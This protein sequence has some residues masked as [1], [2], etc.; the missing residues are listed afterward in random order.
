MNSRV[1]RII[2]E[3]PTETAVLKRL[4]TNALKPH[5]IILAAPVELG[6]NVGLDRLVARVVQ[7]IKQHPRDTVST[8]IDYYGRARGWTD[9]HEAQNLPVEALAAKTEDLLY[10]KVRSQFSN[11]G[12]P[13][14]FLPHVQMHEIE[15]LL[16]ARADLLAKVFERPDL[17]TKV[18]ACLQGLHS[19]EEINNCPE[20]A[21]AARIEKLFG[22]YKK[23]KKQRSHALA[24]ASLIEQM[25]AFNDVRNACPLFSRWVEQLTSGSR[26]PLPTAD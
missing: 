8:F 19:C 1:V 2:V 13:L 26:Q 16:F 4:L 9:R 3:G 5:G 6:G 21:P 14:R 24:Y 11:T 23:G 20:T 10:E 17:E 18:T 15:A 25:N 7:L 22:H 12:L